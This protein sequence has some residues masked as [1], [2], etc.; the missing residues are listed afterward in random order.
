MNNGSSLCSECSRLCQERKVLCLFWGESTRKCDRVREGKTRLFGKKRKGGKNGGEQKKRGSYTST[1]F[2]C[3]FLDECTSI[4]DFVVFY[5]FLP[6]ENPIICRISVVRF[7]E[8]Q[9][10]FTVKVKRERKRKVRVISRF[11]K[12]HN[13]GQKNCLPSDK[14]ALSF[15]FF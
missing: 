11:N 8:Y 13:G 4:V 9:E 10:K 1:I 6:F 14:M 7:P 5:T 2:L 3:V 15:F 12:M